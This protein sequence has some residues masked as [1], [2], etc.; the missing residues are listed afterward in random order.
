M[1][2]RFKHEKRRTHADWITDRLE[3]PAFGLEAELTL[4]VDDQPM[5]P[6]AVFGDP[7]GFIREPLMHRIGTSYHL[8]N[9]AAVYFDTGVIEIATPAIEI[10]RGCVTRAARS[11]WEGIRFIRGELDRWGREHDRR[12]RLQ[13]FS[14]H[15]NVSVGDQLRGATLSTA[16]A[17]RRLART[18]V[19]VLPVPVMMLGTNR[20]STGVGVRPRPARIEITADFTPDMSLMIAVGSFVAG[21]VREVGGWPAP[22]L[23]RVRAEI[24]VI[25][26]FA[27]IRHTSRRGWLAHADCYAAS[28]FACDV[29]APNWT[30]TRGTMSLRAIARRVFRRFARPIAAIADARA[31]GVIRTILEPRGATLLALD[32]RPAS[33]DDV[34]ASFGA[35]DSG[36]AR[37]RYERVVRNAIQHR[38]LR[39][40]GDVCMPLAV[41]GWSRV[42]FR[43]EHD[44]A[45]VV[46]PFDVLVDRLAEWEQG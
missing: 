19:F 40:A 5:D 44:G 35:S 13:G 23:R 18:L 28:P 11:L 27:P 26:R 29:D 39:L 1:A 22:A 8:P 34:G 2:G 16:R 21:V 43:R 42:V 46:V 31:L 36:L 41:R 4:I 45:E 37:S 7:R 33:Y 9:G 6:E 12:V 15:Y 32:D 20:R 24:P 10:E 25:R 38:R 3:Q 30:T 14:T 17:V